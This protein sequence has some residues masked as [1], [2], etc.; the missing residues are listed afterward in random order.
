[1]ASSQKLIEV[2][3]KFESMTLMKLMAV[4]T[5]QY[6]DMV[7]EMMMMFIRSL[8]SGARKL[9]VLQSFTKH[10]FAHG[11]FRY[12]RTI[13][14]YLVDMRALESSDPEIYKQFLDSS[15][16]VNKNIKGTMLC[17]SS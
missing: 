14:L 15:W 16:V 1:M 3:S 7:I 10:F 17:H 8:H 6:M 5:L 9:M 2:I 12:A 4:A 13:L 11:R